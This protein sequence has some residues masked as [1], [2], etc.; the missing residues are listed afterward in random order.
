[1]G[2]P[3]EINGTDNHIHLL[4]KLHPSTDV[5]TLVKE[6][7]AYSTGWLKKEGFASFGWQE[8]YGAFSHSKTELPVLAAYIRN[9]KEHH[10]VRSFES[11]IEGLN[12]KWEVDWVVD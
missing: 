5:S 3:W 9:Q 12:R 2:T 10:K 6:T 8:G 7:K 1:M 4:L 11:E